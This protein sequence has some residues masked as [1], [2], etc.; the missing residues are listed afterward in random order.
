VARGNR[1]PWTSYVNPVTFDD[2]LAEL[3]VRT[4]AVGMEIGPGSGSDEVLDRLRKGFHTDKITRLSRI[5]K[6]HGPSSSGVASATRPMNGSGN[7][8]CS[9]RAGSCPVWG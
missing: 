5:A 8:P 7:A 6:T 1:T 3:M 4:R 9:N 2:E